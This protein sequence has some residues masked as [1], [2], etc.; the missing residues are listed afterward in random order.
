VP[1][2]PR[3][4]TCPTP[5]LPVPEPVPVAAHRSCRARMLSAGDTDGTSP[6]AGRRFPDQ[7]VGEQ[8]DF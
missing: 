8:H 6:S 4:L 3:R 5:H 7:E 2:S 1:H